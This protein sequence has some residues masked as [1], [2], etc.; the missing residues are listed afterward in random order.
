MKRRK[1]NRA[2]YSK[3]FQTIVKKLKAGVTVKELMDCGKYD[4]QMIDKAYEEFQR[5]SIHGKKETHVRC[6]CGAT[7]AEVN[8]LGECLACELRRSI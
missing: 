5:R 4:F 7:V 2:A 6:K 1:F 3:S 8:I